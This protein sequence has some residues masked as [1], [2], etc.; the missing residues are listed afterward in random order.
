MSLNA[1]CRKKK[2]NLLIGGKR[3]CGVLLNVSCHCHLIHFFLNQHT[4]SQ[5]MSVHS[6]ITNSEPDTLHGLDFLWLELTGKCNLECVH[7]YANSSPRLPMNQKMQL[8]DWKK[9]LSDANSLGC[10]KVQFIG[11][12]P[13]VYPHLTELIEY[14]RLLGFDFVEVF[15]NGTL[16]TEKIK[17]AFLKHQVNLAF[18]VYSSNESIHDSVTLRRGS[19]VKTI[20]SLKWAL[21]SGLSVRAAIIDVGINS[22]TVEQTRELLQQLGVTSIGIDRNRGIGRG[23]SSVKSNSPMDELCGKCWQG[24][25]CVTPS[26]DIFPCVFSRFCSVGNID[27]GLAEVIQG[28]SLLNFRSTL[29]SKIYK[30]VGSTCNP[31]CGPDCSP[32]ECS[33]Q[34]DCGPLTCSPRD[35]MIDLLISEHGIECSP[36]GPPCPPARPCRPT[37]GCKPIR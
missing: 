8:E 34:T 37:E 25:L 36:S 3:H 24:K 14:A 16:F 28:D 17:Q 29:K 32:A 31:Q 20:E 6:D 26:G 15:T 27:L 13:T 12:E 1:A 21:N 18:S 7:C 23:S 4:R 5:I 9:T 35:A 11:G 30:A 10:R 19:Y 33:P 22:E 2:I